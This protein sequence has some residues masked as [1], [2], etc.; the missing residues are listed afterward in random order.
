[1]CVDMMLQIGALH[2]LMLQRRDHPCITFAKYGAN[3]T[4]CALQTDDH[5][6]GSA[7]VLFN[8][9]TWLEVTLSLLLDHAQPVG[10]LGASW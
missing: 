10:A 5:V 7:S 8:C 3:F 6:I 1:M 4:A 2:H 9:S